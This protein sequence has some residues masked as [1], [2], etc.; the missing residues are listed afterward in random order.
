MN[1]K[2]LYQIAKNE[3]KNLSSLEDADF[4]LEQAEYNKEEKVWEI[5]VSYL[6]NNTE[7]PRSPLGPITMGYDF[8]RVYKKVKIDDD[9]KRVI[10]F[11]LFEK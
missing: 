4:R 2:E 5:V 10:G 6:V 8:Q 9:N 11:Y 3:L 1:F 7:K